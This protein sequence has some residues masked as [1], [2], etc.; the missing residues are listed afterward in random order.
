MT[1][2]P[3]TLLLAGVVSASAEIQVPFSHYTFDDA[4]G[5][6]A[7]DT[8]SRGAS[9]NATVV[10]ATWASTDQGGALYFDGVNDYVYAPLAIP[11]GT[12]AYT[13]EARVKF[14]SR[15][16]WSTIVKNWGSAQSGSF[17]FGLD[18]NSGQLSN[19][20]GT[21]PASAVVDPNQIPLNQWL[22]LSVSYDGSAGASNLQRLYVNG[23]L[24]ASSSATGSVARLGSTMFIGAKGNDSQTGIASINPGWFHGY[25]A[26][27]KFYNAEV[28][29]SPIPE[30]STYGLALASLA[31]A[32]AALRRRR[33]P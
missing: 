11:V 32:A 33:R 7:V 6:T 22:T 24:V 29:P 10:G 13:I 28:L 12:V 25:M 4:S 27:L 20:I 8:G 31:L 17:H 5:T 26:D 18:D 15:S 16:Q 3:L 1:K 23:Q 14:L 30:P 9:G 2:L 21:N 19:Y